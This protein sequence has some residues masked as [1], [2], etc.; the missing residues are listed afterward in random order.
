MTRPLP[1]WSAAV[2]AMMRAVTG[3]DPLLAIFAEQE[4]G[5]VILGLA[6][7]PVHPDRLVLAATDV[8]DDSVSISL[9][10]ETVRQIRDALTAWLAQ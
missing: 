5:T 8:D 2:G 10:R 7:S 3:A 6:Q 9:D 4:F 1:D